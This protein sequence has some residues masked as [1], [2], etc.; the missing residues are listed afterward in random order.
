MNGFVAQIW[1]HPVKSHGREQLDGVQLREGECI[2]WDRRWAVL[3]EAARF[4][5]ARPEWASCANFSRVAK[6][7]LLQAVTARADIKRQRVT[8]SHPKLSDLTIN[9]DDERDAET[10][11]QWILPI[12]PRDRALPK[13]LVRVPG[14]GM[15]D[16]DYPSVSLI[17]LASHA[18]VSER[19]GRA[20]SHLR[21]RGNIVLDG[22]EPW[23]ETNWIGRRLRAG[24]TEL[25][26]VEPTV[27]CM[28]TTSSTR[29][30]VRDADVLGALRTGWSHQNMGVYA[31]VAK[32]G[33]LRQGDSLEP[34]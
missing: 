24:Q 32:T 23:E 3:H 19:I 5:D 34:I 28:A 22:L 14:R 33:E 1:R 18:E 25:E 27:R 4:D 26:I 2:P 8:F 31:R 20:I 30:G 12:S 16:T 9:P 15:T 21:W 10:F 29:T 17:N 6:A 13:R 11:I 7:P